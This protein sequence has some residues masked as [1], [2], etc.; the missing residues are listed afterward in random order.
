M[1]VTPTVR[2][3][4]H[5]MERWL[6]LHRDLMA[7]ETTLAELAREVGAGR[8]PVEDLMQMNML[9]GGLR[10]LL[11]ALLERVVQRKDGDAV[12]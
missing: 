2:N 8:K 1:R 4:D 5:T 7:K 6:A 12:Q 3:D 11:D 9:V 10:L